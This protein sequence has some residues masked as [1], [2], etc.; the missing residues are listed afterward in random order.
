MNGFPGHSWPVSYPV[1]LHLHPSSRNLQIPERFGFYSA[2]WVFKSIL[3]KFKKC[4][5]PILKYYTRFTLLASRKWFTNFC[6]ILKVIFFCLFPQNQP[7]KFSKIITDDHVYTSS[8]CWIFIMLGQIIC[9][10]KRFQFRL[11][12]RWI[13]RFHPENLSTLQKHRWFLL[14]LRQV[15]IFNV[16]ALRNHLTLIFEMWSLWDKYRL[17]VNM[18]YIVGERE[19]KPLIPFNVTEK[20]FIPGPAHLGL[21]TPTGRTQSHSASISYPLASLLAEASQ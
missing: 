4:S 5:P 8:L 1:S 20:I 15:S 10:T 12:L 9:V 19:K 17:N 7:Q 13:Q 16:T 14:K 21:G 3:R 6:A 18:A 2:L 11:Q